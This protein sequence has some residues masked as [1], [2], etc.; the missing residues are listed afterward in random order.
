MKII[1]TK[2]T[3]VLSDVVT[4]ICC[5]KCEKKIL[6]GVGYWHVSVTDTDYCSKDCL[7]EAVM[8]YVDMSGSCEADGNTLEFSMKHMYHHLSERK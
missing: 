5:D 2:K 1:K 3:T 8:D 7:M 4:G 6:P